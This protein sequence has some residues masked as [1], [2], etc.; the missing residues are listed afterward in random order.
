MGLKFGNFEIKGIDVS[1]WQ[2]SIE[3]D[4]AMNMS[5]DFVA[6]KV[7]AGNTIDPKF[8][9]NYAAAK[10]KVFRIAYWYMDYYSNYFPTSSAYGL[11]DEAWGKKQAENC[12][13]QIKG[14]KDNY[15]FLDI[16][17]AT[18][19]TA[20][21][22]TS[23]TS[24][25]QKIAR[26]FLERMDVLN[27]KTNGIYCSLGLLTWFG[28]WF[29]NRPLWVAWYNEVMSVLGIWVARSLKSVIDAVRGKGWTGKVLMWQYTSDGDI[30]DNG[31]G[32]GVL[33]GMESKSLDL[34]IWLE[35]KEEFA[36]F[37]G[38]VVIPEPPTSPVTE[39]LFWAQCT[40]AKSLTI[41]KLPNGSATVFGYLMNGEKKMVYEV[42]N[43]WYRI[44][45][46]QWVYGTY[47]QKIDP[48]IVE[49]PPTVIIPILAVPSSSQ[50]DDRWNND[51]LGNSELTIGSD[52][53]AVTGV[54]AVIAFLTGR[55]PN[56]GKLNQDLKNNG[57]FEGALIVWD[58]VTKINPNIAVD[59]DN[60][61]KDTALVTEARI[62][63]VLLSGRPVLAQVDHNPST[64]S[65]EPHWVVING[66]NSNGYVIMDSWDGAVVD[67]KSRY[68]KV[69][70][71][72][73]FS[74]V[75]VVPPVEL[76]ESEKLGKLWLAHP[77]LH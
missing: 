33:Y 47:M 23:Y 72:V 44:G 1:Q 39:G 75:P 69:L 29:R 52:G 46:G 24:R 8:S 28:V 63:A 21:P 13:N 61:I 43:G 36:A 40:A 41:R 6:I 67:L 3:F 53:C 32:D 4:K 68:E 56:P 73:A 15:V 71:M 54:D 18:S 17:N 37:K 51:Q 34:N 45:E 35:S 30:D 2:G 10:G 59:W 57:G 62:D 12:W 11:S 7:G 50:N 60:F 65:L 5:P 66:K 76:T 58:A 16:E 14:D 31:F 22:V 27:G 55:V 9:I 25:A 77:D 19:K 64:T 48:A 26:A 42:S 38:N 49:P 74:H 70:R 20:L